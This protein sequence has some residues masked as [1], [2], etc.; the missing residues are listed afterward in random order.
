M[1]RLI[2]S[3]VV[4]GLVLAMTGVAAASVTLST[5]V[6]DFQDSHPDFEG[7]IS[8]LE[9]GIVQTALGTDGKPV[10]AKGDGSTSASTSGAANFNQ[11]YNDVSGV[12]LSKGISLTLTDL[13]GGIYGYSSS[14]FFPIDGELFGNEGR[15]HNYHFTM[16]LHNQFTYQPGQKFDFTGDDD[17][18]VFIDDTLV[19]D[20]GG[21]HGAQHG[22]VDLDALGLT[23]G[24][25]YE[26]DLFFAER[27]TS[28]SN[29]KMETSI[30]F[31]PAIPAPGALLLGSIGMGLVGWMRRRRGL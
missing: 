5:T 30:V 12:N 28:Q 21:V 26:F 13:G 15:S 16:E 25:T 23:D 27:H 11:W 4:V 14:D 3:G 6:R 29:F 18:W 20:L 10:Y 22:S 8:G 17:V 31:E 19:M 1:R 2:E 7:V 9:T 24:N